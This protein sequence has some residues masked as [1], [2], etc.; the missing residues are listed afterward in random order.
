MVT[1]NGELFASMV[2]SAA[3]NLENCK[4]A[5][6]DMNVF[7][8][9]DGDTGTN[10]A[11]TMMASST[12]VIKMRG[13][14]AGALAKA[15]ASSAL[16]GARGNSGVILSQLLR[17]FS[18]GIGDTDELTV[19]DLA[20]GICEASKV[21]YRAVMKPTEGTIL[22]VSR[23]AAD[24]AD[25]NR[26]MED[27]G[28]FLQA[29]A[30]SARYALKKT[31]EMLPVLK[32][33]GVV[34]SGGMGLVKLMEGALFAVLNGKGVELS[35]QK[36]IESS[37]GIRL[38]S[39]ELHNE[40]VFTYCTEFI[41]LKDNP[42]KSGKSIEPQ[43]KKLGDCVLVI[44]DD[45]FAKVHIHT[46]CP[47]T[48]IQIALGIGMLTDIKIDN[49]R[50]QEKER[51]AAPEEPK[52]QAE[53]KKFGFVGVCAGK[54][55]EAI[56]KDIGI[57]EVIEGGQTMNP[58]ADDILKAAEKVSAETVF[59]FPNNKNIIL[60]ARQAA[61]IETAK[62][63]VVIP[64]KNVPQCI[65]AM[66][67]F[68]GESE[69]NEKN[70]TEAAGLVKSASVTYAVR[71]TVVDGIT[72][73]SGDIIGVADDGI[74][75]SEPTTREAVLKSLEHIVDLD[76]HAVISIYYGEGV[77]EEEAEA[78]SA[79]IESKYDEFDVVCKCG[80]QPVY[81]YILSAE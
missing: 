52:A 5:V 9:P 19:D 49:L 69:D 31:P 50:E 72:V 13:M 77:G 33:A 54:G 22:T 15:A 16:R 37:E 73:N 36:P 60:A 45:G 27:V 41:I 48:V 39:A 23:F 34:D 20:N 6:N 1:V 59:V 24:A 3:N 32:T 4:Q 43:L 74:C 10:M 67:S 56:L 58:C 42:E 75:C 65:S 51:L 66:L 26:D 38:D 30:L 17:G 21:A 11:K 80:G 78:L 8:V 14:G 35:E 25:K 81:Y 46:D 76:E 12:E 62:K 29:I 55:L 7:P 2:V 28:E 44:D 61:E 71:D 40:S 79:E 68:S 18:K 53:L 63:L 70:M 64:T 47:G 57:D